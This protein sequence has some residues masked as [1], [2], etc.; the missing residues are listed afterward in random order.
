MNLFWKNLT[1]YVRNYILIKEKRY[2]LMN[3]NTLAEKLRKARE[4]RGFSQQLVAKSLKLPRTAI[5]QIEAG[6]RTVSTLELS[7]FSKL[8][9]YPISYFF[10]EEEEE[11][12]IGELLYRAEPGLQETH[13]KESLEKYINLC[14][15]GV[16]LEEMLGYNSRLGPPSYNLPTPQNKAEAVRQGEKI[17][18][19]ERKRLGIGNIPIV[20]IVD[21][22]TSQNI[23]VSGIIL[24]D[25]ISGLVLNHPKTGL[26]ILINARHVI[27]RKR[28]S[29]AHEYAHALLDRNNMVRIS[30]VNN[31]SELIEVR[32]NAFAASF[33]MPSDNVNDI[34]TNLNKG[35]SSR[36]KQIIFDVATG[37][38]NEC[39]KRVTLTEQRITHQDIATIAHH[40]GVSYQAATYRLR[41]LSYLS[42]KECDYLLNRENEGKKYLRLL[43]MFSDLEAKEDEKLW[44]R[45]LVSQLVRLAIEAYRRGEISRGR[46]LE[47]GNELGFN[48][49]ALYEQAQSVI[50]D[51]LQTTKKH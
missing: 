47:L 32:A 6:N 28:F 26:T 21:L 50:D 46:I 20:D 31:N 13:V 12:E 39:E 33:L 7:S 22:I 5:T 14:H 45:E 40:F 24:P 37:G 30:T 3:S 25:T 44:D 43:N 49:H 4:R 38:K 23:W 9:D 41:S 10:S 1:Y 51:D 16:L 34:L 29:Y 18:E 17:A 35:Q 11:V 2:F 42:K 36:Q 8:Y 15:Q 48:G 27:S 19:Q